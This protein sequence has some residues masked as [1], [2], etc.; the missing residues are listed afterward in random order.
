MAQI[1][2]FTAQAWQLQYAD[3]VRMSHL[4][5]TGN[6]TEDDFD[7]YFPYHLLPNQVGY[8]RISKATKEQLAA[9]PKP[10]KVNSGTSLE[11]LVANSTR[12]IQFVFTRAEE[13]VFTQ[14]HFTFDLKY[15]A[16]SQGNDTYPDSDNNAEGAYLLKPA[17][18]NR[19]QYSY[20]RLETAETI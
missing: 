16:A 8:V 1:W 10:P 12:D 20:S 15:Y 13:G 2:N 11:F 5:D 14:Q 19:F 9:I 6:A 17:M 3:I 18:W 4:N 7:M